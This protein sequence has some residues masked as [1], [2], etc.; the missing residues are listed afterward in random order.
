MIVGSQAI[1][2]V[3]DVPPEIVRKSIECD[4]LLLKDFAA[5]RTNLAENLGVF[6]EYQKENGIYADILGLATV[7]LQY[8]WEKRLVEL[9]NEDGEAVAFCVEIHDVAVSKLM[10]GREKDF[11]FLQAVFQS[12]YLEIDTF[13]SRVK[14][15]LNSPSS[16]ALRPCL[17]KLL[18]NFKGIETLRYVA[19]KLKEFE[20]EIRKL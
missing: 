9:K 7:V 16:E 14:L 13:V 17:Q 2:A 18:E 1:F 3:T 15:I 20:K 10:A 6:S 12:E 11:E 4:F 5:K 19:K 8:G